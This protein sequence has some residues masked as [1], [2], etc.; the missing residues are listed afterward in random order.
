MRMAKYFVLLS[1]EAVLLSQEEMLSI[2]QANQTPVLDYSLVDRVLIIDLEGEPDLS[3]AALMHFVCRYV[4]SSSNDIDKIFKKTLAQDF[5]RYLSAEDS[6]CVRV[7]R[8]NNALAP[9]NSPVLE[10]EIGRIIQHQ[11]KCEVDLKTPKV[12]FQGI[13]VEGVFVF[14]VVIYRNSRAEFNQRTPSKRDYFMPTSMHPLLARAMVNLSRTRPSSLFL[15]PFLGTGGLLIEAERI[16]CQCI[17]SD[18]KIAVIRGA[19]KNVSKKSS[20]LVAD[21]RWIPL[22]WI[23]CISTDPPYGKNSSVLGELKM[24]LE[25]FLKETKRLLNR[26]RWFCFAT[27]SNTNHKFCTGSLNLKDYDYYVHRSLSRRIWVGKW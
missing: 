11:T 17:G 23:Q 20:L 18:V 12:L 5:T 25:G 26:D 1:G 9:E 10:R 27:D 14:G 16:G 6:F 21:S 15:D 13:I 22:R 24:V 4:F 19:R 7:K 8:V 3:R 2:L